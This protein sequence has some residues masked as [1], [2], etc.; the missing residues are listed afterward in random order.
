MI[1]SA[2]GDV[3]KARTP[4]AGFAL[5]LFDFGEKGNIAYV[6]NANREDMIEALGELLGNLKAE[7]R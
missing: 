2:L 3:L 1:G 7:T 6:S 4:G 5:L